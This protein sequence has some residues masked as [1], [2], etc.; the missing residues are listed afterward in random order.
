VIFKHKVLARAVLKQHCPELRVIR[1][2]LRALQEMWPG[3]GMPDFSTLSE[4]ILP[5]RAAC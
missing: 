1:E 5:P 3:V 2:F 4:E